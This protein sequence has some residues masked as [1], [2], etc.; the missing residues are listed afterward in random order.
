MRMLVYS[1]H[2]DFYIL[3]EHV[4]VAH[5]HKVERCSDIADI[6]DYFDRSVGPIP[7]AVLLDCSLSDPRVVETCRLLKSDERTKGGLVVGIVTS[8]SAE[9]LI[10]LGATGVDEVFI[11]PFDPG[12]L[13]DYF[14]RRS[15]FRANGANAVETP[16]SALP[17]GEL[18]VDF[19]TGEVE[20]ND[21]HAF[22]R[23]IELRLLRE[24]MA[25]PGRVL[26]RRQLV[27]LVWPGDMSVRLRTVDVHIGHL[28]KALRQVTR[29]DVIRTVRSAGYALDPGEGF[30]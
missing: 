6:W 25:K 9:Q 27:A 12:R 18:R 26:S 1:V 21:R 5:G 23:P 2:L 7:Q 20:A 14:R 24:L 10:E 4:L 11:R 15:P 30:G 8:G 16:A 29:R 22:L 19:K 17:L 28:R 3:L 13:L